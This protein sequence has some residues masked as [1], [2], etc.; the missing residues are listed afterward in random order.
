MRDIV[1]PTRFKT[2]IE[3]VVQRCSVL[4]S[5][6]ICKIFKNTSGGCFRTKTNHIIF[7]W[8]E[9]R[10]SFFFFLLL[11]LFNILMSCNHFVCWS[12][13]VYLKRSNCNW[14][15]LINSFDNILFLLFLCYLAC[16]QTFIKYYYYISSLTNH[17]F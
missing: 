16:P 1:L 14:N 4:F 9:K 10:F 3:A 13:S 2:L 11:L 15:F 5:C 6:E 12:I 8:E 7:L 17:F